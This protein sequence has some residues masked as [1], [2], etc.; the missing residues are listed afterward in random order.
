MPLRLYTR[1]YSI[2]EMPTGMGRK[3][4]LALFP[5][6]KALGTKISGAVVN[7]LMLIVSKAKHPSSV[8]VFITYVWFWFNNALGSWISLRSRPKSGYHK[9]D[10][11]PEPC[12]C[13]GWPITIEVS[14][15]A[16]AMI[17][18]FT[19]ITTLEMPGLGQ[20]SVS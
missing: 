1:K 20:P 14:F 10:G 11:A 16:N 7:T 12:N 3:I 8:K 5:G 9:K 19:V 4:L 2:F 18:G 13:N 15:P 6:V 17:C